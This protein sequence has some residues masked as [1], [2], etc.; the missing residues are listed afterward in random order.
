M[1]LKQPIELRTARD[2]LERLSNRG[3]R[4]LFRYRDGRPFE[5]WVLEVGETQAL[6][7]AAGPL[8][9]DEAFAVDLDQI[10]LGTLQYVEGGTLVPFAAS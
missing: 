7:S 5:G 3:D 2:L 9:S 6:V 1:P 4:H 10:D 8:G